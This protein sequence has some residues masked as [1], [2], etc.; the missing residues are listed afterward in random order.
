MS[1]LEGYDKEV[2]ALKDDALRM[3]WYMR[4]GLSYDDAMLLSQTEKEII[5]K[6]VKDNLETTQ[7]SHLPFF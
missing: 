7:K 6:I 2:R 5:N 1:L 4:G 3:C